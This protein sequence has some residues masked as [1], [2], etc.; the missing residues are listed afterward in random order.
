MPAF[1]TADSGSSAPVAST[2]ARVV[3]ETRRS[4][5][6]NSIAIESRWPRMRSSGEAS[7]CPSASATARVAS[8]RSSEA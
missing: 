3:S 4:V 2:S 7:S 6:L 1:V 5:P 8:S